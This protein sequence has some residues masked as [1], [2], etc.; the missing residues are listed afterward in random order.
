[1]KFMKVLRKAFFAGAG[2]RIYDFVSPVKY[3]RSYNRYLRSLGIKMSGEPNYI[4]NDAYF[5]SSDYSLIELGND[6]VISKEVILLTHDYAIS[7][8]LAAIGKRKLVQGTPRDL[9][10]ISIGDNSFVGVRSL[11]LGTSVEKNCIIGA[12]TVVKGNI[13]DNSVVIGNSAQIIADIREWAEKRWEAQDFK[14]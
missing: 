8:G 3:M 6:C 11:L 13:P 14:H 5:D 2:G 9:K 7:R 4:A 10:P 12:G 1:M